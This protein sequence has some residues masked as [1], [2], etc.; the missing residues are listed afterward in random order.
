MTAKEFLQQ[1]IAT[2]RK[3]NRMLEL[4]QHY[5]DMACKATAS[6]SPAPGAATGDS[7]TE[8]FAI[9]IVDLEREID[10]EIDRYVEIK[11]KARDVIATIRDQRFRN[12]LEMRYFHGARWELIMGDMGYERTH[13]YRLHGTALL[14]FQKRWDEMGLLT[15]V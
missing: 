1:I 2:D 5:R 10:E 15:V 13:I 3:I 14:E 11:R 12:I 9:K 8:K 7:R 6:F 4:K